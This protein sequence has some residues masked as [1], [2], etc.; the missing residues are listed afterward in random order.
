MFL[1]N[2]EDQHRLIKRFSEILVPNGGLLFTSPAT[3]VT[4]IDVMTN[5]ESVSLG[6]EKYKELMD[7]AGLM[8]SAEYEDE[9]KNHYFEAFKNS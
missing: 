4:W 2:V 1:L 8:V 5:S 7:D 3:P 6:A 9:G